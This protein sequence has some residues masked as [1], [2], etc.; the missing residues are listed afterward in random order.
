MLSTAASLVV[1]IALPAQLSWPE[2]LVC[3]WNI[4]AT[5]LLTLA[6]SF[7]ARS[8]ADRTR[9]LAATE[10]PGRNMVTVLVLAASAF[11]LFAATVAMR[12]ARAHTSALG[13]ALVGVCAFAVVT[14][15]VAAHSAYTLRYAHLY[16]RDDDEGEGGLSFPGDAKPCYMDFAYVAFVIGMCFQVSDVSITSPIIRRGALAH[17]LLSFVYNT[18]IV[19]LTLNLVFGF[20]G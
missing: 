12:H 9:K 15:W 11:S 10:D 6:W 13:D 20:M 17:S 5:L 19:A 4:G 14:A 18:I 3:G 1:A 8:D 7:I 2:R 16:Y